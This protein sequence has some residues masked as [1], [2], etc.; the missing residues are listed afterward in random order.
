VRNATNPD[1]PTVINDTTSATPAAGGL[2]G[3]IG[4]DV[5]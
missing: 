2:I 5:E 3:P 4:Y 1:N